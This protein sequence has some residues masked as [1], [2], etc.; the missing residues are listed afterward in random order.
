MALLAVDLL[1]WAAMSPRKRVLLNCL[2]GIVATI[3]RADPPSN[4]NFADR[5]V[6]S[7]TSITFTG[8]LAGA[9][10]ERIGD[11][12]EPDGYPFTGSSGGPSV[13]WEWT[14]PEAS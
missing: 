12:Y 2:L 3:S 4:D 7:G 5:T 14:A 13:W 8:R 1:S 9:T 11:W 10:A 6:L